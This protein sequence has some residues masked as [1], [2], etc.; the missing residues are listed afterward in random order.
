MSLA[1][2]LAETSQQA[3]RAIKQNAVAHA[4]DKGNQ[5]QERDQARAQAMIRDL[6]PLLERAAGDAKRELQVMTLERKLHFPGDDIQKAS[7]EF[8]LHGIKDSN[9]LN[10]AWTVSEWLHREGFHVRIVTEPHEDVE[11]GGRRWI[12]LELV[13]IW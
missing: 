12:T 11:Q 1:K 7:R 6:P 10:G 5:E 8:E 13:A 4:T 9:L 2:R 3:A